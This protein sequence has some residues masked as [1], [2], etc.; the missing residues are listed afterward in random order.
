MK[1]FLVAAV[2]S[3]T[4]IGSASAADIGARPYKAPPPY[5]PVYNWTGFYI[6]GGGGGGLWSADTNI[7]DTATGIPLSVNQRQGGTGWFGTVGAGYDWQFNTSWVAGIFGDGQFGSIRGTIQDPSVP[8][9]GGIV[10]LS[11]SASDPAMM[12]GGLISNSS[13]SAGL[14]VTAA[15]ITPPALVSSPQSQPVPTRR[16]LPANPAAPRAEP[17]LNAD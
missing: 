1:K 3:A 11:V 6:F 2:V 17:N 10:G 16:A 4:M 9:S 5:A 15:P 13:L 7:Q 14:A 12:S 8:L